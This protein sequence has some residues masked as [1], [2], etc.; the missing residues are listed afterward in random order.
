[1]PDFT[2]YF[3][4]LSLV[5]IILLVLLW[6]SIYTIPPYKQGVV[7]RLGSYRGIINPGFNLVSPI[8]NVVQV[9]LR[10]QHVE[11][12]RSVFN[13]PSGTIQS[14]AAVTYRVTDSAKAVFQVADVRTAIV[15]S[16][17]KAILDLTT[18]ASPAA[19]NPSDFQ[20]AQTITERLTLDGERWGLMIESVVVQRSG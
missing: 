2:D 3:L 7:T 16:S 18:G 5:F 17:R 4:V 19:S 10:S 13:F 12:P 8:G 15:E 11:V 20:L 14:T 9:D 1:M 6:K